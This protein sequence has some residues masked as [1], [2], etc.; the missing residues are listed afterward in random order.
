MRILA[1]KV[2]Y[3][4]VE[5]FQVAV[6]IWLIVLSVGL[7]FLARSFVSL[8]QGKDSSQETL[9]YRIVQMEERIFQLE[10][11]MA[12]Y[13]EDVQ[14]MQLRPAEPE[15]VKPTAEKQRVQPEEEPN[16]EVDKLK[17]AQTE[18]ILRRNQRG[19]SVLQIAKEMDLGQGEVQLVIAL[20]QSQQR[21][22]RGFR[23]ER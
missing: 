5:W 9:L 21:K 23:T 20:E 13:G 3:S 2:V 18:E 4:L 12:D 15:V 8:K 19:Q 11:Q 7:G 16:A 1:V 6:L 22:K 14:R 10:S 17:S